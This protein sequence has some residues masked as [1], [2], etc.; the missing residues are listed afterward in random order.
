MPGQDRHIL[1]GIHVK[2]RTQQAAEVQEA[3]TRHGAYIKTRLGLHEARPDFSAT[4]GV[5]LLEMLDNEPKR[6][7]LMDDL[8]RIPGVETQQMIFDH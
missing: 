1:I 8:N 3:L 6:A 7:A 4:T 2:D 5:I